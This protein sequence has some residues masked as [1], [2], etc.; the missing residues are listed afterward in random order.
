MVK[1]KKQEFTGM[2]LRIPNELNE[3]LKYYCMLLDKKKSEVVRE[4]IKTGLTK[5]SMVMM[6]KWQEKRSR[7]IIDDGLC[8]RCDSRK[9]VGM[10]HI[11][12][13]IR[14]FTKENIVY[15]CRNCSKKLQR[16]IQSYDPIE[17][18]AEWFFLED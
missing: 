5:S 15:L 4:F 1:K 14:N 12:G 6:K 8:E 7:K 18:F 3:F 13:N 17:K 11:D 16:H 2:S 10:Y 9:D